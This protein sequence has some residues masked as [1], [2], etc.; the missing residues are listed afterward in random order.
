MNASFDP[1]APQLNARLAA[2]A[3]VSTLLAYSKEYTLWSQWFFFWFSI[4]NVLIIGFTR[5]VSI[6]F[7][8][9]AFSFGKARWKKVHVTFRVTWC[10]LWNCSKLKQK[11]QWSS[12]K[13][14]YLCNFESFYQALFDWW[15]SS[16]IFGNEDRHSQAHCCRVE[17][18]TA[19]RAVF[20]TF[21]Q[22]SG[23]I[24]WRWFEQ[25]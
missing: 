5:S 7:I 11:N 12:N 14:T 10:F 23:N 8:F 19:W 6:T 9:V 4:Q 16:T 24:V 15:S 17:V 20:W 22:S 3:K 25:N 2:N 18:E 1:L 13:S 21:D